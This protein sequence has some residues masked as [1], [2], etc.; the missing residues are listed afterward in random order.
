M[1]LSIPFMGYTRPDGYIELYAMYF[2]FPL[3]DTQL[4]IVKIRFSLNHFQFPLWDTILPKNA[5][6][7]YSTTFNSLYGIPN[8][9][10]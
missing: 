10:R 9:C 3:W 4:A 1:C 5:K 6:L 7:I 8:I 2:Q